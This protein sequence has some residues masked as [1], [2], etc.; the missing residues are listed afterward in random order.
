[1]ECANNC[2]LHNRRLN[3]LTRSLRLGKIIT[4]PYITRSKESLILALLELPRDLDLFHTLK[5]LNLFI[6]VAS[7]SYSHNRQYDRRQL[8]RTY[9]AILIFTVNLTAYL[10]TI[11]M[12]AAVSRTTIESTSLNMLSFITVLVP[13]QPASYIISSPFF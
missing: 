9:A 7:L 12:C 2:T 6:T 10:L 4:S 13:I 8:I 1:M 3:V 5:C 11:G